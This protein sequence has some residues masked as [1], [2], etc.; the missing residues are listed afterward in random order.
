MLSP[1]SQA[2]FLTWSLVQFQNVQKKNKNKIEEVDVEERARGYL[3]E[4]K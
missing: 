2:L 3:P 1:Q 4:E